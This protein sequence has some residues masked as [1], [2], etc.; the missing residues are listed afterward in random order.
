[1]LKE[2]QKEHKTYNIEIADTF[3]VLPQNKKQ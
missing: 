1:M 2:K 3:L